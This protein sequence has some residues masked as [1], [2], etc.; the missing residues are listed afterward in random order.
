MHTRGALL[1]LVSFLS[2]W[3]CSSHPVKQISHVVAPRYSVVP[4]SGTSL[5]DSGAASGSAAAEGGGSDPSPVTVVKTVILTR[6]PQTSTR[7]ITK[8]SPIVTKHVTDTVV[9]ISTVDIRPGAATTET[10]VIYITRHSEASSG[11]PI[12]SSV[13]S[14]TSIPCSSSTS[15]PTLSPETFASLPAGD[16]TRPIPVSHQSTRSYDNGLWHT[17]YPSW[18]GTF[19][20]RMAHP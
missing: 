15:P 8:S 3:L 7:T 17:T 20:R 10:A 19:T 14:D 4:I 12:V 1:I 18:N 9:A 16:S 6:P 13:S 11:T 5:P 2:P